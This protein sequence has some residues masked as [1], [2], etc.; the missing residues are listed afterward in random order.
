MQHVYIYI[1]RKIVVL[2]Y[3]K[4]NL[5]V[6]VEQVPVFT[7]AYNFVDA[8]VLLLLRFGGFYQ[9]KKLKYSLATSWEM[10]AVV[11]AKGVSGIETL[12][13]SSFVPRLTQVWTDFNGSTKSCNKCK[14]HHKLTVIMKRH[15]ANHSSHICT[16]QTH[17]LYLLY[18][19]HGIC[20]NA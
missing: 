13:D 3:P 12:P 11:V 15:G 2:Q 16:L 18:N 9:K 19:A 20:K 17:F 7:S 8:T 6:H 10:Q 5:I 4:A 14:L 1:N